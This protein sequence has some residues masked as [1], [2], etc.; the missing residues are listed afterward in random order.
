M[1]TRPPNQHEVLSEEERE[2]ARVVRALPGGEPPSALDSLILKAASDA[3]A[4]APSR[5]KSPWARN[6]VLGASVFWLST[7]AASVLTV[8]IGWQVFQSMR[9]P[10]YE[11]PDSENIQSAQVLDKNDKSESLMVDMAP[12]AEPTGTSPPP[13]PPETESDAM[14]AADSADDASFS[15][16]KPRAIAAPPVPETKMEERSAIAANELA[17][18][19][20]TAKKQNAEPDWVPQASAVAAPASPPAP[21]VADAVGAAAASNDNDAKELS[22][23][24]VTGSRVRRADAESSSPVL[25]ISREQIQDKNISE[26]AKLAP[27]LWLDA[28]RLR[29]KQNDLEGAKASLKLFKQTHPKLRIP[30]ELKPLL[31]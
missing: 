7:A 12:A 18:P 1:N 30:K 6:G 31:K 15:M 8:G 23:V 11:L 13:P 20:E 22:A 9:A 16:E 5:K 24:S 29:V 26:D 14:A 17:K 25:T 4:A 21:M 3:V 10:I 2:L 19:I 28:I 27:H